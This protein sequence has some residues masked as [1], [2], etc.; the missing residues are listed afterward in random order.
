M[1]CGERKD[2]SEEG[3]MRC[4]IGL[5]SAKC[6]LQDGHEYGSAASSS[7]NSS[8]PDLILSSMYYH[9]TH[10]DRFLAI[11]HGKT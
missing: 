6:S 10:C 7:A 3:S 4:G 8:I 5:L 9:V 1:V 11:D 2:G